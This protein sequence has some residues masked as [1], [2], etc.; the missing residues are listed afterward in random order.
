MSS[1]KSNQRIKP[2]SN[3]KKRE[4]DITQVEIHNGEAIT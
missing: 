3:A 2:N 1:N 4:G